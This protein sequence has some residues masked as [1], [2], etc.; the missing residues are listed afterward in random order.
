MIMLEPSSKCYYYFIMVKRRDFIE[1]ID[2]NKT[3][4]L[5]AMVIANN[6]KK[7]TLIFSLKTVKRA[8]RANYLCL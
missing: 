4:E 3:M 8:G 7:A 2:S 6:C 1:I 5:M